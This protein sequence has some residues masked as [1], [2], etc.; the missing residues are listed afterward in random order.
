MGALLGMAAHLEGKGC[1][2][3]DFTGLAQKNGAVMSHVRIAA[4]ARGHSRRAHRAGRRRLVLGC[5]MVVAAGAAACRAHRARRDARSSSTA[6]LQPTAA[7][8]MNGDIEFEARAMKRAL[9]ATRSARAASTFVDATGLATALMGDSIATNL[10]ML[11]YAFQKGLIPLGLDAIERAIE[12]NGVAVEA[13]KHTFAWGGSR[14]RITRARSVLPPGP[15]RRGAAA[16]RAGRARARRS[17]ISTAYQ[18]AAYAGA[19]A[20]SSTEVRRG[21][22]DARERPREFAEA[23]AHGLVQAHGLQGRIRG[24]AALHRRLPRQAQ[25]AIR[26]RHP[27]RVQLGAAALRRPRSRHRAPAQAGIRRLDEC[28]HRVCWREKMKFLRGTSVRSVR[29]Y[30]GAQNRAPAHR[31]L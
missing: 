29:T 13:N 10:F 1:T 7:F 12:L 26:G 28:K 31:R 20:N 27:P 21:R 2:V 8:V 15:S 3:L 24:G 6:D 17:T 14:R 4:D 11:G 25:A 22:K 18:D 16:A 5:D 23:V 9:I 30:Q 19:T